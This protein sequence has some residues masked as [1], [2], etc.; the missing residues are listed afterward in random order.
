MVSQFVDTIF[1]RDLEQ[2]V[3]DGDKVCSKCRS[4]L[5]GCRVLFNFYTAGI[6]IIRL[7]LYTLLFAAG[8]KGKVNRAEAR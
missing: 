7:R 1:K 4:R 2:L 5:R 8:M 6:G 3:S